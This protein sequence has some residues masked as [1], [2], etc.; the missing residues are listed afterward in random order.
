MRYIEWHHKT[1]LRS[2]FK[3]EIETE[4]DIALP[5]IEQNAS[6]IKTAN[7]QHKYHIYLYMK[8]LGF[9]SRYW[10]YYWKTCHIVLY[11]FNINKFS[12]WYESETHVTVFILFY[13]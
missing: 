2:D 4:T 13:D 7:M 3:H 9:I 11:A 12:Y 1:H 10:F 6:E 5:E 8:I